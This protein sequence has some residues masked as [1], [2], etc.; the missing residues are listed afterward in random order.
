MAGVP[1]DDV[2]QREYAERYPRFNRLR[3]E[4]LNQKGSA[5]IVTRLQEVVRGEYRISPV[6]QKSVTDNYTSS[7]FSEQIKPLIIAGVC[8]KL[9]AVD[10]SHE[11]VLVVHEDILR[12]FE[13]SLQ[14]GR[15][16]SAGS[17][18]VS[19][20]SYPY[21]VSPGDEAVRLQMSYLGAAAHQE[22]HTADDEGEELQHSVL[23]TRYRA[24]LAAELPRLPEFDLE[25]HHFGQYTPNQTANWEPEFL[26]TL[27]HPSSKV[28]ELLLRKPAY[29]S[30]LRTNTGCHRLEG[31]LT[32]CPDDRR[33]ESFL[34][35]ALEAGEPNARI[36]RQDVESLAGDITD[37]RASELV[38]QLDL[39]TLANLSAFLHSTRENDPKSGSSNELTPGILRR[40][41]RNEDQF[42]INSTRIAEE[43]GLTKLEA[44]SILHQMS[45]QMQNPF[46]KSRGDIT[47]YAIFMT[48]EYGS[49]DVP[50][51][52]RRGISRG[53]KTIT[54]KYVTALT[55]NSETDWGVPQAEY[56]TATDS[57]TI[58]RP[59][60][61]W[62]T[63]EPT[64]AT[65]RHAVLLQREDQAR[66][67][68][69]GDTGGGPS[70]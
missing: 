1:L 65:Q 70:E 11:R 52:I 60:V 35:D 28:L 26:N 54:R 29:P 16:A 56:P 53:L 67:V 59:F 22:K 61:L 55:S 7:N 51:S 62:S 37:Q 69:A 12:Q 13:S 8:D 27:G 64:N 44:E 43:T 18:A 47:S 36:N 48:I 9:D 58:E 40:L 24:A 42:G 2:A 31:L 6:S 23:E 20:G 41:L 45:R 5:E 34:W 63:D 39:D 50:Q 57:Y 3:W 68:T 15:D 32:V 46:E 49:S 21:P 19:L 30:R 66:T 14:H 38:L 10:T 25:I 17:T 33:F 4:I